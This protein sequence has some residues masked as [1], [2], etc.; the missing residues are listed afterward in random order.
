MGQKKIKILRK[1]ARRAIRPH[2]EEEVKK[3]ENNYKLLL[4]AKPRYLP[5]PIYLW[6]LKAF[7]NVKPLE[8]NGRG[9]DFEHN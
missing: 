4:R 7:F 6:L 1:E 8:N 3:I 9:G 5:F 2:I